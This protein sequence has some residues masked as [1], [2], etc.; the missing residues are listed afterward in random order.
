MKNIAIIFS[1]RKTEEAAM[2]YTVICPFCKTLNKNLNLLETNGT[3]ECIACGRKTI[4]L[5]MSVAG[6][7][8]RL[9]SSSTMKPFKASESFRLK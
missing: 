6:N 1:M 4:G 2:K 7:M 3:M 8:Q 9:S 5:L